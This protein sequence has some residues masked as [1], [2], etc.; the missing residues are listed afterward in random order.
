MKINEP[1]DEM[2]FRIDGG[3]RAE[4]WVRIILP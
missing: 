1:F 4:R 3:T 2:I